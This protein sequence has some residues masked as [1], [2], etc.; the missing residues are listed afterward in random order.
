MNALSILIF[1]KLAITI[2][3]LAGPFL[4]LPRERLE[5]RAGIS[6]KSVTFFRLYGMAMLAL[7]TAYSGGLWLSWQGHFPWT[8]VL[9][10]SVSNCGAALVLI[11]LWPYGTHRVPALVFGSIGIGFV[12]SALFP[13]IAIASL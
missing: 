10:G 8:V 1:V 4:L 12:L 11:R 9:M 7:A 5:L 2:F 6:A 13:D 3:T